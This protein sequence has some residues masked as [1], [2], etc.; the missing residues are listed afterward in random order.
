MLVIYK[1]KI[2]RFSM[3][4]VF[5]NASIH[6]MSYFLR[7]NL[8][9]LGRKIIEPGSPKLTKGESSVYPSIVCPRNLVHFYITTIVHNKHK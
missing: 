7:I 1:L 2:L 6:K 4:D 3:F 9:F 8:M 5:R